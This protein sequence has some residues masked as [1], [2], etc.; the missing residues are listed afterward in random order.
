MTIADKLTYL[1]GTKAAIKTAIEAKGVTVGDA[2]FRDY[3][4]KVALISGG[5]DFPPSTG[6]F[7]FKDDGT[8]QTYKK[9]NDFSGQFAF[10]GKYEA[11]ERRPLITAQ[12]LSGTFAGNINYTLTYPMNSFDWGSGLTNA[13][14]KFTF[15]D[16]VI[17]T[18]IS[19][20]QDNT[21]NNGTWQLAGS[22]DDTTYTDIADPIQIG[23]SLVRTNFFEN[24][25]AYKYYTL[26]Q[27]SGTTS[28]S[29]YIRNFSFFTNHIN[30]Y[31]NIAA[32]NW[33][34]PWSS[35]ERRHSIHAEVVSGTFG[36]DIANSIT[37]GIVGNFD[38]GNGNTTAK[39]KFTS[40]Y[41]IIIAGVM[42]DNSSTEN[43]GTWQLAGSNDDTTYTDIADPFPMGGAIIVINEFENIV[44]YK[45]YTLTQVGGTT[46]NRPYIRKIS[47]KT[48]F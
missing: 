12:V 48:G 1:N 39:L 19:I 43:N 14:L 10:G 11:G 2:A 8:T 13:K 18:G 38:W 15:D 40:P 20:E 28:N 41:K 45:Y 24:T 46:A 7:V 35:G 36:G 16:S 32:P 6:T 29:P 23:L 25:V 34:G 30:D 3:A 31:L 27:V 17:L 33:N 47:F 42:F 4:D 26:T 21:T 37:N 44:A 9:I 22:N 5:G